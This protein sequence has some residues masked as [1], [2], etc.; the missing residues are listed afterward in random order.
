MITSTLQ[1]RYFNYDF[2]NVEQKH[3]FAELVAN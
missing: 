2:A 1:R 3:L